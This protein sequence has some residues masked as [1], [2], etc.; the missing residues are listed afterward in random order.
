MGSR[1]DRAQI[2]EAAWG[3]ESYPTPFA[4]CLMPIGAILLVWVCVMVAFALWQQTLPGNT[5]VPAVIGLPGDEAQ[6]VLRQAGLDVEVIK[7]RQVNE[8]IPAGAVVSATPGVGRNVKEG[9]VV[10]LQLS[11]GSAFA[12]VPNVVNLSVL[13]A[14]TRLSAIGLQVANEVY[15]YSDTVPLDTVIS[16]TPKPGAKISK[17][18]QVKLVISKGAQP[19]E[20]SVLGNTDDIHS[21]EISIDLPTDIDGAAEVRIDVTDDTGKRTVYKETHNPGDAIA[22]TV[23]GTGDTTAELFFGDRLLLTRKF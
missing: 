16:V 8:S 18:S 19:E 10:H 22:M 23:E 17:Q 9:R 13:L 20:P 11:S 3:R 6:K 4:S 14:H 5:T 1:V 15:V 2:H 7:E 21:S 12:K